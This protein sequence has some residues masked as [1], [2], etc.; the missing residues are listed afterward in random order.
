VSW[1]VAHGIGTALIEPRQAWQND[2]T[3][4]FTASSATSA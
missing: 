3:E 4:G 1:I 2:V